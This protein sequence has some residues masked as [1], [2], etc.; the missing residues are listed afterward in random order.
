MT[1]L[2]KAHLVDMNLYGQQMFPDG[3]VPWNDARP[4]SLTGGP[5]EVITGQL[6]SC[7]YCGSMHPADVATAIRAGARGEWADRKYGWPHK[8]Y[9][10][11][12]P[13]PHV[14]LLESRSTSSN[15]PQSEIDAGKW[16][17]VQSGYNSRTGEP[18]YT[19]HEVGKPASLTTHGKFYTVHLMDATPEDRNVIEQN[20]G[21]AFN[22]MDDGR[23]AW[24]GISRG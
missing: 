21:I 15:P 4:P 11:D 18:T 3:L 9:F 14:G 24:K 1:E 22:F 6:R 17:H 8:A 10:H 13:N 7:S 2:S 23:V 12:I 19:W 5:D 20:L 16:R